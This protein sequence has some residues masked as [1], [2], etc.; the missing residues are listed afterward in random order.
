MRNVPIDALRL[1]QKHRV[2]RVAA[3]LAFY[4]IF[5]VPWLVLVVVLAA[6]AVLGPAHALRIIDAELAPL[7]G[8]HGAQGVNTLV[9]ASQHKI[10]TAPLFV[11]A[12]LV[13]VA[14]FAIFMQVQEALDDVWEI[15]EHK[16]GGPWE[17]VALRLHSLLA[18][19]ALGLV[20]VFALFAAAAGGR[21]T[22]IAVNAAAIVAFLTLAYRVLPRVP[23]SWKNCALGALLT[24]AVLVLGQGALALYFT[25]FHPESGYGQAG[26]LIIVLIW[27]YYSALL[28][29]FGAV[30][31]NALER[32]DAQNTG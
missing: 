15:P 14:V 13:I 20:A 6:R 1:W 19:V 22:A 18:I 16:R 31:A 29:L 7:L 23:V 28:F 17:I 5:T 32:R 2:A 27:I 9:Q 8:A 11:S 26:S 3:A 12:A 10:A 25:R 4:A 30:L 24:G 21:I